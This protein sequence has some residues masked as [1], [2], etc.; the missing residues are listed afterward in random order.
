MVNYFMGRKHLNMGLL[1]DMDIILK[2]LIVNFLEFGF[3]KISSK[4]PKESSFFEFLFVSL[5]FMTL[6]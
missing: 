5:F 6:Y 2:F 1:M 4:N 3:N